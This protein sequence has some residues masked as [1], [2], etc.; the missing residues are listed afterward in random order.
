MPDLL[1]ECCR[2]ELRSSWL[3]SKDTDSLNHLPS[4]PLQCIKTFWYIFA[5]INN[6]LYC[7]SVVFK[8]STNLEVAFFHTTSCFWHFYLYDDDDIL[9]KWSCYIALAD[10]ELARKSRVALNS[11]SS[12][13]CLLNDRITN[14]CNF[15]QTWHLFILILVA[16]FFSLSAI[17]Y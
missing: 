8:C 10:L 15:T 12:C 16:Y 17:Y 3:F 5:S 13:L 7:F 6:V 9:N 11:W 4:C 2:S 1:C 14:T